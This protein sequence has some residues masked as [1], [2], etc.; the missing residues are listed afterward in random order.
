MVNHL[1]NVL[2]SDSMYILPLYLFIKQYH[3]IILS[4]NL[5]YNVS[6]YGEVK[7]KIKKIII[8]IIIT[9]NKLL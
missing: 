2:H 6:Y 3:Y 5:E 7:T 1:D 4:V 9:N 8:T